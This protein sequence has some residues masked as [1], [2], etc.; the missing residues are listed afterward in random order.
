[1]KIRN[2]VGQKVRI[3]S[4]NECYERFAGK[5]LVI[6]SVSTNTDDHPGFDPGAGS[7]LYDFETESGDP[8]P[9]S[10]YEW[11]FTGIKH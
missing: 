2:R 7:A 11:E 10:L 9:F 1:M 8:V 6:T 3:T 4:D 5:V